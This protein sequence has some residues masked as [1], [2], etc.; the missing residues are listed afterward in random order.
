[1]L[2][3]FYIPL[4]GA[5][6]PIALITW[7]SE[8]PVAIMIA[9]LAGIMSI[10]I[11]HNIW[12]LQIRSSASPEMHATSFPISCR[13]RSYNLRQPHVSYISEREHRA[14]AQIFVNNERWFERARSNLRDQV[15]SLLGPPPAEHQAYHAWWNFC[16]PPDT[17]HEEY[18]GVRCAH[19][20]LYYDLFENSSAIEF[21]RSAQAFIES[22][23]DLIPY[24]S[25]EAANA[26]SLNIRILTPYLL[27][28]QKACKA[29]RLQKPYIELLPHITRMRNHSHIRE[30][31]HGP[32]LFASHVEE[33]QRAPN[34]SGNKRRRSF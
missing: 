33:S 31:E 24:Q 6:M 19:I 5:L 32:I 21:N 8:T 25:Q 9:L 22:Y 1:V 28:V 23:K 16:F 14:N 29:L 17:G 2:S 18:D 15:H 12:P 7:I 34:L 20:Y 3:H 4:Q 10:M 26:M 11:A 30:R 13:P 27:Q